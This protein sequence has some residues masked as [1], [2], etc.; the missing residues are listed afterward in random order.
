MGKRRDVGWWEREHVKEV[1]ERVPP[2][3]VTTFL[4][5]AIGDLIYVNKGKSLSKERFIKKLQEE[6]NNTPNLNSRFA[7][8]SLLDTV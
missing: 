2:L 7:V 1:I 8:L 5:R 3:F 4:V 6:K